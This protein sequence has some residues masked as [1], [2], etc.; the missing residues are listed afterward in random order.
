MYLNCNPAEAYKAAGNCTNLSKN[1]FILTLA[2]A[3][4]I[5]QDL[6]SLIF[7]GDVPA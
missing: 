5:S 4:S 3:A 6:T 2:S 7:C 1:R